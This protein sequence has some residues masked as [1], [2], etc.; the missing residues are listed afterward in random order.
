VALFDGLDKES[1]CL[2]NNDLC[3]LSG[4]THHHYLMP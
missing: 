4:A 3:A 1:P 2:I